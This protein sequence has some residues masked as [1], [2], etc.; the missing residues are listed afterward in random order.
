MVGLSDTV[1]S[2]IPT[3]GVFDTIEVNLLTQRPW[4]RQHTW[5]AEYLRGK[6]E[7]MRNLAQRLCLDPLFQRR[8]PTKIGAEFT[9]NSMYRSQETGNRCRDFRGSRQSRKK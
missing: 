4:A 6:G 3:G 9:G 2:P 7:E 5:C 1:L 8:Q